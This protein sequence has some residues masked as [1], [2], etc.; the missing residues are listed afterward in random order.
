VAKLSGDYP[1]H[2]VVF[3]DSG[4]EIS[5]TAYT[6]DLKQLWQHGAKKK[7]HL[8]HYVY[9]ADLNSDG[10]DK[11][12]VSG[13]ELDAAGKVLWNRYDLL[14]DN[15]DHC[16]SLRFRDLDGDG[17]QRT[18]SAGWVPGNVVEYDRP[19]VSRAGNLLSMT[20]NAANIAAARAMFPEIKLLYANY[21]GSIA[22][23]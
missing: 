9:P 11:V 15:H 4:G 16:D 13:L 5:I 19:E 23:S 10:I 22:Q 17:Q 12:S 3:T 20:A 18:L 8:G 1:N 2:P 21:I 7:D 14:D 6:H